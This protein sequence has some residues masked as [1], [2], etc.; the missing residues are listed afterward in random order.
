MH[1]VDPAGIHSGV[2]RRGAGVPPM[3][4]V[5]DPSGRT[6]LI[7]R[8][9]FHRRRF[10]GLRP[11]VRARDGLDVIGNLDFSDGLAG[12]VI[13][14]AI[15]VGFLAVIELLPLIVFLVELAVL[16]VAGGVHALRGRRVV[17]AESDG[18]VWSWTVQ[19]QPA[20]TRLVG[21]IAR[22]V[23]EGSAFPPDGRC[24]RD[25]ASVA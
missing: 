19:G 22:A 23:R 7:T 11:N 18:D 16:A 6:W 3:I 4:S 12:I 5:S 20:A 1:G 17:V 15:L 25:A 13:A 14:A 8:R 24:E 10:A 21:E 9:L 2:R